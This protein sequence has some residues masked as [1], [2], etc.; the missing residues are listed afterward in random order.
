[1]HLDD[2]KKMVDDQVGLDFEELNLYLMINI[3]ESLHMINKALEVSALH[4]LN[5]GEE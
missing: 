2:I 4:L 1:M 3:A 5:K